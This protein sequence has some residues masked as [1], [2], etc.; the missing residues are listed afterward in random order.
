MAKIVAE[1]SALGLRRGS[2]VVLACTPAHLRL[3][4]TELCVLGVD[5]V[6]AHANGRIVFLD[7]R[8]VIDTCIVDGAPDAKRFKEGVTAAIRRAAGPRGATTLRAWGEIVDLL[9]KQGNLHAADTLERLWNEILDE[10][11]AQLLCSYELDALDDAA[12]SRVLADIA[13]SHT[14]V[15]FCAT[16]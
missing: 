5:I 15:A 11:G 10:T 16:A 14:G 2:G 7:A 13:A 4:E 1:W 3:V 8:S 12:R 9:A 6:H